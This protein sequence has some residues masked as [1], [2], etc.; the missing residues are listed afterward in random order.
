MERPYKVAN[1]RLSKM[2][3]G[4]VLYMLV[5]L[6][7]FFGFIMLKGDVVL[8]LTLP[9]GD[10]NASQP[11]AFSALVNKFMAAETVET[12]LNFSVESENLE[13][14]V[15]G[16]V[17][18]DIGTFDFSANLNALV[19]GQD[20]ALKVYKNS[21]VDNFVY[22]S[23]NGTSFK[24]S[25]DKV[26]FEDIMNLLS[27][28]DLDADIDV[29]AIM[30]GLSRFT[31]IDF[32]NFSADDLMANLRIVEP[33]E[34][35][36]GEPF[37]IQIILGSMRVVL[38]CDYDFS[39]IRATLDEINF[40]GYKI[41]FK[42]DGLKI[43]DSEFD[44]GDVVDDNATDISSIFDL[45]ENAQLSENVYSVSSDLTVTLN[46]MSVNGDMLAVL[47]IENDRV[48]P[49]IRLHVNAADIGVYVYIVDSTVYLD[50]EDFKIFYNITD[51]S[52][53][54]ILD[55]IQ[56]DLDVDMNFE[57]IN[58][59]SLVLPALE[60][61]TFTFTD[62][63]LEAKLNDAF[64][65]D[66][67]VEISNLF[68]NFTISNIDD[69]ILPESLT[70]SADISFLSENG[71]LESGNSVQSFA[72]NLSNIKL[73]KEVC[74]LED[75]ACEN[76]EVISIMTN[77][78]MCSFDKFSDAQNL[79][80][81]VKDFANLENVS[82]NVDLTLNIGNT[83]LIVTGAVKYDV[84]TASFYIDLF[85]NYGNEKAINL[86]AYNVENIA[87]IVLDGKRFK[88][89]MNE[90][91]F[92]EVLAYLSANSEQNYQQIY[93]VLEEY[94]G[95]NLQNIDIEEILQ[96]LI[97]NFTENEN[98]YS[99]YIKLN[100]IGANL[101]FD[102]NFSVFNVSLDKIKLED[103]S[104]KLDVK[105]VTINSDDFDIEKVVTGDEIDL[106]SIA[107]VVKNAQI[108][109]NAFAISGDIAIRYSNNSF[110]GDLFAMAQVDADKIVPYVRVY[111]SSMNLD[112]YIYLIGDNIYIDLHGL[113]F[114]FD[115]TQT[116][117][118]EIT[119]FVTDTLGFEMNLDAVSNISVILPL[120]ENMYFAWIENGVQFNID[121]SVWYSETSRFYDIVL[122][123]FFDVTLDGI[124][125]SQIVLGANIEDP[126]T[127][128]YDDYSDYL[129][130][131]E[132]NAT[133]KKNFAVYLNNIE[134][135]ENSNGF[136]AF[137]FGENGEVVSV[138]GK[139]GEV[140]LSEFVNY[141]VLLDLAT[142]VYNYVLSNNYQLTLS[143]SMQGENSTTTIGGDV[144]FNIFDVK[145]DA[146]SDVDNSF[147]LF[148]GKG[149]NVQGDLQ[150]T[151]SGVQHLIS[152]LY[153]S[154]ENGALYFT[155]TH[156]DFIGSD[157]FRGKIQN[158]SLSKII[159]MLLAFL[160]VDIGEDAMNSWQLEECPTDFR[161]LQS[162]IGITE[163]DVSDD[164]SQVDSI[165]GSVSN[166]LS[167]IEEISV[168]ED[169]SS[170]IFEIKLNINDE[171]ATVKVIFG[172]GNSVLSSIEIE[173]VVMSGQTLNFTI[174]FEEYD[175]V[176]FNYLSLN[177]EEEH[178]DLSEISTFADAV[179]NTINTQGFSFTGTAN[180]A[181]GS[182][183]A[184]TITYDLFI[185]LSDEGEIY[186]YL[187]LDVPSFMDVTYNAGGFGDDYTYYS[188]LVGFDN[189]I[190]VLE[191]SDNVLNVTQTT[192][193]LKEYAWSS[194]ET[195]VKTWSHSADEIGSDIMVIMAEALGL[196]NTVYNAIQGLITSMNPNPSL[197]KTFMDFSVVEGGYN[198]LVNGATLTGSDSFNDFDIYLGLSD[199]YTNQEGKTYKFIDE[200]K[201]DIDIG[202]IVK[203][204]VD[205][206]SSTEGTSYT[207]GAGKVINTNDY[208]RKMYI[209][210]A[211]Y[212]K[213]TFRTYCNT[214]EYD[215]LLLTP[216]EEIIFPELSTKES[217]EG[218]MTTYYTFEGWYMDAQFKE[219]A[220]VFTMPANN[221]TFYA[222]WVVDRVERTGAV[223]IYEN[224]EIVETLRVKAGDEIDPYKCSK[225][226][227]NTKFYTDENCTME[228]TDWT[229]PLNDVNIYIK[230]QYTVTLT[231]KHNGET[232][233]TA[234][235]TGYSGD[236][237]VMPSAESYVVDDGN[238]RT[239]YTFN[240]YS[241]SISAISYENIEIVAD[242]S[243]DVKHYYTVTFDTTWVKP[244]TWNDNNSSFSGKI[245]CKRAAQTIEAM[246]VLE[247]TVI[248]L[249][250]Y[251]ITANYDYQA[252]WITANYEFKVVS[253]KTSGGCENV[254]DGVTNG[255]YDE[256]ATLTVTGNTTLY[257]I[258]AK[259]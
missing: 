225:V 199:V 59:I 220:N 195:R 17:Q 210:K 168:Y 222:K 56:N 187:E 93:D 209:D 36:D 145:V 44:I 130:T 149:L 216:G 185:S 75:F 91:N 25:L 89:D 203:I 204:P 35:V 41:N 55:L 237:F 50:I 153:D 154:N 104:L 110:Y 10:V 99:A 71:N 238:T 107:N 40:G 221:I 74:H 218:D 155:Y 6:C 92:E 34:M 68:A 30:E 196:T 215:S 194:K 198:L 124:N 32:S 67:K 133:S 171:I 109:E 179:V 43:N 51:K 174:D 106:M 112:T 119:T 20:Y 139:N 224:G 9:E 72:L 42:A 147:N 115:L 140:A 126:N 79:L 257:A 127:V 116:T 189:R 165:L 240:G 7:S 239:T 234:T 102:K 37:N 120:F 172:N 125:P 176:N 256:M 192:Y 117:F 15:S 26:N 219:P 226:D 135:G 186:F 8:E 88:F 242:W 202:G 129:L 249:T 152:L 122:Q 123:A 66:E 31:G 159:S 200:V 191:Y 181:I 231:T 255:D 13:L 143:G 259:A 87:Y 65:V 121:D 76:G 14:S 161:F 98:G 164:I 170:E 118:D 54:E 250:Q 258:W 47:S 183:D 142:T 160:N 11:S 211:R 3:K 180:V 70:L 150:V 28:L 48:V 235:Y 243:V 39:N 182:W 64:V 18:V 227:V 230:N 4:L 103:L 114:T 190:S 113:Q 254:T 78:G 162:L 57:A 157:Y 84:I 90:M 134:L 45:K 245:T 177:P 251:N 1:D 241:Q 85:L 24:L 21:E 201:V 77:S 148:G 108:G 29:D 178:I 253:W 2:F 214:A 141:S 167:L 217:T 52:A 206:K 81:L 193:G 83:N 156:G 212:N 19:N 23:I 27:Q 138:T 146:D 33:E 213:V 252:V 95:I 223:N 96:N 12:D 228:F 169:N 94:L 97:F 205:L 184:I 131:C 188:A 69:V 158:Q 101:S 197:E 63:G 61:L 38:R 244:S 173:N 233:E 49:Y 86:T 208:Y 111:T 246:K 151:S 136:T 163:N 80:D 60:N 166:M 137:T 105:N 82:G 73:G 62:N 232:V 229:M 236:D 175:E 22:A 16:D 5:A 207:T 144:I 132:T 46:D 100:E 248:D 247:G 58:D 53:D 128:L